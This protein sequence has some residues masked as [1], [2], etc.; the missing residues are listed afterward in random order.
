MVF[1]Y[2]R[3]F[4]R[5]RSSLVAFRPLASEATAP[6][7][8]AHA[9]LPASGDIPAG[10]VRS[11]DSTSSRNSSGTWPWSRKSAPK[12]G[13]WRPHGPTI[14]IAAAAAAVF[15]A[16]RRIAFDR[17]FA[18]RLA[19]SGIALKSRRRTAFSDDDDD[20]DVGVEQKVVVDAFGGNEATKFRPRK[21]LFTIGFFVSTLLRCR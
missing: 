15:L 21:V 19:V 8:R 9:G 4:C 1:F 17:L 6:V 18:R 7:C 14:V 3:P 5:G 16:V 11:N 20:D 2:F 12:P 10:N 13:F